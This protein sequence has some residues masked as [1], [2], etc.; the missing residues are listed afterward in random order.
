M[1]RFV[2]FILKVVKVTTF[3]QYG[4]VSV[5]PLCGRSRALQLNIA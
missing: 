1:G 3:V 4:C 5:A 2:Q